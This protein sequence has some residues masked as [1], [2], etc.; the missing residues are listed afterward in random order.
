M[1]YFGSSLKLE[2]ERFDPREE[3][4]MEQQHCGGNTLTVFREKILPG[5]EWRVAWIFYMEIYIYYINLSDQNNLNLMI[6]L[7][8]P[9]EMIIF[10]YLNKH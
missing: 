5:S 6:G 2:G 10:D 1:H 9:C 4:C 7:S 8:N 3:V